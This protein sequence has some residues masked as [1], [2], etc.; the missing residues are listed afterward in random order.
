MGLLSDLW[1]VLSF[2]G[3]ELLYLFE[4]LLDILVKVFQWLYAVISNVFNFL[5]KVA[6]A[7]TKFVSH[8]WSGFF[9]KIWQRALKYLQTAHRWLEAKLG[10]IVRWLQ[11]ARAMLDR[12]YRLYIK[13]I[14]NMLQ[15]IRQVLAVL[16]LLHVKWA[17]ELDKKILQIERQISQ[18]FLQIRGI[19]TSLINTVT[20][21]IDAPLLFKKPVQVLSIRR[22]F[23]TLVRAFTGLPPSYFFPSHSPHAPAGLKP[24]PPGHSF[25]EPEYNPPASSFLTGDDGLG[26]FDGFMAGAEPPD[27]AVD[28]L[29]A[30]EFFSEV[31]QE[32]PACQD[33]ESCLREAIELAAER[34]LIS[35]TAD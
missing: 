17:A 10:P 12:Y 23:H 11:R 8:I 5:W 6:K 30:L 2:V 15:K 35:G 19:F 18:S 25:L 33:I 7:V 3:Q 31:D 20:T 13:P 4:Y 22:T 21:V 16:R 1:D 34:R 27:S 28:D 26:N 32:P 29:D 14:L 24:P 9:K